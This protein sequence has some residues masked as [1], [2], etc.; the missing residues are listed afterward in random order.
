MLC[1]SDTGFHSHLEKLLNKFKE[2][3]P[4]VYAILRQ[5]ILSAIMAPRFEVVDSI[6]A[7]A[8]TRRW[9]HILSNTIAE[10]ALIRRL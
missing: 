3:G 8:I 1:D 5:F 7:I 2:I 10:S 4:V 9:S 6:R